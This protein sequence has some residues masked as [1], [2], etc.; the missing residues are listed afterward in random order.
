MLI[1]KHLMLLSHGFQLLLMKQQ[2][3]TE[4]IHRRLLGIY[5]GRRLGSIFYT[6]KESIYKLDKQEVTFPA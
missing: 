4:R 5:I 2:S 3:H 6:V 1:D